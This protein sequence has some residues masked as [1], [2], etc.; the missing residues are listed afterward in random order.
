[1][2]RADI[3]IHVRN[4]RTKGIIVF[5]V[6]TGEELVLKNISEVTKHTGISGAQAKRLIESG[7]ESIRGWMLD[8]VAAV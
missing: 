1:M 6:K 2:A 4:Q 3:G 5:N 8:E 7:K